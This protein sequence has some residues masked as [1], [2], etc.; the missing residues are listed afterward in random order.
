MHG[1]HPGDS[2][3]MNEQTNG[4]GRLVILPR[5]TCPAE[6]LAESLACTDT[7]QI[8]S[9][10]TGRE[11]EFRGLVGT[12]ESHGGSVPPW[13]QGTWARPQQEP[14]LTSLP[15]N[16][17]LTRRARLGTRRVPG[18][19]VRAEGSS[20][21]GK[22]YCSQ[23]SQPS[24]WR[25]AAASSQNWRILARKS[26]TSG[27]RKESNSWR[28]ERRGGGPVSVGGRGARPGQAGRP[29]PRGPCRPG[30]FANEKADLRVDELLHP[31]TLT[32]HQA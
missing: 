17:T 15:S 19:Q 20:C 3:W 13:T 5:Q 30:T 27:S 16:L 24:C 21:R 8:S 2:C 29:G 14:R 26:F 31:V 28:P 10:A 22:L 12:G 23:A 6:C 7:P 4:Q 18:P 1:R 32:G 11:S 9:D 25:R